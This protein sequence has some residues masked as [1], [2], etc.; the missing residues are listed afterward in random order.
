M[1][2]FASKFVRHVPRIAFAV[3]ASVSALNGAACL[4]AQTEA[5]WV[6]GSFVCAVM[7]GLLTIL[8]S[9]LAEGP[10]DF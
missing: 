9:L 5:S 4:I 10:R 2:D 3:C 6:F 7:F 1:S 8:A